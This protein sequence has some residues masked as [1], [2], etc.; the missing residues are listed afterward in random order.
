MRKNTRKRISLLICLVFI[1]L[2]ILRETG[3]IEFDY[4]SSK[5]NLSFDRRFK[6]TTTTLRPSLEINERWMETINS[7]CNF[8]G[9]LANIPI[10]V[11]YKDQ[12]YGDSS[13]CN[14]VIIQI[15][16]L[17]FGPIWTP[18]YKSGK[19]RGKAKYE[20]SA[21]L[22]TIRNDTL[23]TSNYQFSDDIDIV[24]NI[25]VKGISS[26]RNAKQLV[27]DELFKLIYRNIKDQMKQL[28]NTQ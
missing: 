22:T 27:I 28:A 21:S 24:G 17:E 12:K 19:I 8:Q 14:P 4:Y 9:S 16:A 13:Y 15:T 3:R 1:G 6:A 7:K 10:Q 25:T 5:I 20:S 11:T 26:Y 2:T 18:L 23:V